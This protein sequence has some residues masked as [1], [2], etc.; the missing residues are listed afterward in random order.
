MADKS[1]SRSEANRKDISY[2]DVD[3][4]WSADQLL[5]HFNVDSQKVMSSQA[6]HP[7][8]PH[9]I[10]RMHLSEVSCALPST[11]PSRFKCSESGSATRPTR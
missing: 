11:L 10:L 8:C 5:A 2:G 3:F 7:A 4:R 1:T 6:P 9:P